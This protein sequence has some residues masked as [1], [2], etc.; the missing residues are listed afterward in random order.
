MGSTLSPDELAA[1][2]RQMSPEEVHHRNEEEMRKNELIWKDFI[3]NF[4][5]GYCFI[6]DKLLRSF[7]AETPCL[8]WLLRPTGFRKKKHCPLLYKKFNYTSIAAYVR[9]V[10]SA[11][12]PFKNINDI[13]AE[14]PGGKI[15]DLTARYRHIEWSFSCGESDYQ[16]HK[17]SREGRFPHYHFQM[18]L[19]GRPFI[20][21]GD[22]H[23]PLDK[24]DLF[25]I[26]F[27]SR[28]SD[29]IAKGPTRGAGMETLLGNDEGLRFAV[30]NSSPTDDESRAAALEIDT[31][32]TA[33]AGETFSGALIVEAHEEAKSS[34]RTL[35]SVLR[36][37]MGDAHI[38]T[39][40][41]SGAGVPDPAQRTGG[42]KKKR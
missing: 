5:D 29:L 1:R 41:S 10:A 17:N 6:C 20:D 2:L 16:G 7:D 42:R 31:L 18:T 32:V 21:Y 34:G 35:D 36:A 8:H 13:K 33:P 12:A 19:K 11:E 27:R 9:W 37:K 22:F 38:E 15:I 40:V 23:I 28:H 26:E 25:L 3:S 4:E 14:H 30:E 24:E 39:I